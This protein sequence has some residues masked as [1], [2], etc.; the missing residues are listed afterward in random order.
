LQ[1]IFTDENLSAQVFELLEDQS[2]EP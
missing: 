1:Y 2:N